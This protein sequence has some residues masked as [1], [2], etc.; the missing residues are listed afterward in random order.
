MERRLGDRR[1]RPRF[2]I[3][4]E[5][6]G[7]LDTALSMPL[8]NVGRGGALVR[9]TVPLPRAAAAGPAAARTSRVETSASTTSPARGPPCELPSIIGRQ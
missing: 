8:L 3:V 6:W 5:L 2:E 4:G 9:S 1:G 7:T